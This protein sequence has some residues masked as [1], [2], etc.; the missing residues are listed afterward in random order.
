MRSTALPT[1][2]V[3]LAGAM[4]RSASGVKN[5]LENPSFETDLPR[6]G[7]PWLGVGF[8]LERNSTAVRDGS[9][10]LLVRDRKDENSG[11][12]QN[13]EFIKGRHYTFE[14]YVKLLNDVENKIWQI[15]KVN[16]QV[17]L[18]DGTKQGYNIAF[19][20]F[21][22]STQGWI[23]MKGDIDAPEVDFTNPRLAI[24]GPDSEVNF[25]VD[26]LTLYEMPE[27]PQ[28]RQK[29]D[30]NIEQFRKSDVLINVHLPEDVP[31]SEV[32][33]EVYQKRHKFAFGSMLRD[34]EILTSP[35]SKLMKIAYS[36]FEWG[37][38][39]NYKWRF[40][41]GDPINEPDLSEAIRST[42]ELKLH[43]LKVRGHSIF[44]DV[45][46]NIPEE[47]RYEVPK[48]ELRS[49]LHKHLKHVMMNARNILAQWDVQN[50]HIAMHFYEEKA[51][52]TEL[53]KLMFEWAKQMN[54][55]GQLYLNEFQCVTSG[56]QTEQLY[57][58]AKEY[59]LGG[60]P[61]QGLG[62]QGHTKPFVRPNPTTMWRRID[63]LGELGLPIMMTEFDLGWPDML[64][65]ADWFEDAIRAFFGHPAMHGVIL[66]DFWNHTMR[67]PHKELVRG[68]NRDNVEFIEPGQ[69]WACLVNKEW[70][71]RETVKLPD[72][73]SPVSLRGF[74]GEYEVV[75]HRNGLPV[76]K[77]QF[78]LGSEDA[79]W[80]L[81]VTSRNHPIE[82]PPR[83]DFVK[84]CV[85]HR[86]QRSVGKATSTSTAP[87]LTCTTARSAWSGSGVNDKVSVSC[88]D[89][90]VMT[91]CMSMQREFQWT[92]NGEKMEVEEGTG[93]PVCSA[94]NG[95]GGGG[96]VKAWAVCCQGSGLTCDYRTAGPSFPMD[97][98][99]A[100]ATC[101]SGQQALGCSSYSSFPVS[102]GVRPRDDLRACRA[103]S[104]P[105][106][107]ALKKSGV[108]V[109]SACCRAAS[110]SGE[111]SCK[112]YN[113]T[114]ASDRSSGST[115]SV[116]C[117]ENTVLTGCSAFAEDGKAAGASITKTGKCQAKL[118]DD[119]P[120]GSTGVVAYAICCST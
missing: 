117:P 16:I 84:E 74:Q 116:G 26:N 104:G 31:A 71:T 7:G 52:N 106:S 15:V 41:K 50:E 9:Y 33:L 40:Q 54:D 110:G 53:T 86:E 107:D 101:A 3:L 65:R 39:Q 4:W 94:Y 35:V 114:R 87:G 45:D 82:I 66:W 1:L 120:P 28:W 69:R 8:M 5:L 95:H 78:S 36:I 10:A 92:R 29:A 12:V 111:L 23:R 89:G 81:H 18:S 67:Y 105:P 32:Q 46:K 51:H 43:G 42:V 75:V 72:P 88:P 55:S 20:S 58:L 56:A 91:G 97:G 112:A 47:V 119:L 24:R 49:V 2:L 22:N 70:R 68:P 100:E 80:D 96:G 99:M 25:L 6:R 76:Q 21:C 30:A 103:Q 113:S 11:P 14:G 63:R 60:I 64:Q 44:W 108:L 48:E 79:T 77:E 57:D 61:L 109:Y 62:I 27:D 102:D 13:I 85:S 34:D 73:L 98:A 83:D 19:R 93:T 37:S 118:G 38:V 115:I 90:H 17:I 59:L